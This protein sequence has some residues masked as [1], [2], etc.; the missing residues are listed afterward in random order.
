MQHSSKQNPILPPQR[1]SFTSSSR[2]SA[3]VFVPV[4]CILVNFA[5]LFLFLSLEAC[6]IK[7]FDNSK[8]NN[9]QNIS[10][11]DNKN[12][13]SALFDF[14]NLIRTFHCSSG[15]IGGLFLKL[16]ISVMFGLKYFCFNRHLWV[17]QLELNVLKTH[18]LPHSSMSNLD[19]NTW[20]KK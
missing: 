13:T 20:Y 1:N 9:N 12:L 11:H 14:Q 17:L 6:K 3:W 2:I 19:C 15:T 7:R 16:Y 8:D 10:T 5:L 18:F 4:V